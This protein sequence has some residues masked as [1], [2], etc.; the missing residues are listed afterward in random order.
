MMLVEE[1]QVLDTALPVAAFKDHLRLGTGFSDE[2]VQDGLLAS[3]LRAA[4]AVIE[5]RTGRILIAREFSWSIRAWRISDRQA[6]PV[7]PVTAVTAFE[8]IDLLGQIASADPAQWY[9]VED[10]QS[11]QLR[12]V[13]TTLPRIPQHGTARIQ[14]QAGY[15]PTWADL[16]NDLAHAVMILAAHFYEY[17]H[18]HLRDGAALPL[19]VASLI[20]PYRALRLTLGGNRT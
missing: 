18:S 1:T 15:G 4:L 2:D 17:R 8:I 20:A 19:A 9:L 5:A 3:H 10:S 6:L 16:P 14:F 11:P 7:A 13:G 12:A